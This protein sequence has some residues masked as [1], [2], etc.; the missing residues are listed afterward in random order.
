MIINLD[1]FLLPV[2]FLIGLITSYEDVKTG[3]IRNK[4]LTLGLIYGALFY[5]AILIS[6]ILGLGINSALIIEFFTNFL[7][8]IIVGFGL[9]YLRVWS[10]G[11]GK[12]FIIF[13]ILLPFSYYSRGYFYYIPS[14]AL[15][16]NILIFGL[17]IG[18]MYIISYAKLEHYKAAFSTFIK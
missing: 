18:V 11:D 12:L 4:W 3:K 16:I 1:Y 10:A 7:F 15:L 14:L 8:A 13:A 6:F 9:W 2:L 17:A 5:V